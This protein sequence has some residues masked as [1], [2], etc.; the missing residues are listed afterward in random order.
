MI[1]LSIDPGRHN[2]QAYASLQSIAI[3]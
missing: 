1:E 2:Q 3:A